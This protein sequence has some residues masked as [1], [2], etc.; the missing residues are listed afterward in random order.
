MTAPNPASLNVQLTELNNRSRAYSARLWYVPLAYMGAAGVVLAQVK[1]AALPVVLLVTGVVGLLLGWH[2]VGIENGRSRATEALKHLEVQLQLPASAQSRPAY[3]LPML[4]ITFGA[5]VASLVASYLLWP[6]PA[7]IPATAPPPTQ[8]SMPWGSIGEVL[9]TIGEFG[10]L[11][12]AVAQVALQVS[13]RRDRLRS[14]FAA[15]YAEYWRLQALEIEWKKADLVAYATDE[16]L[17]PDVLVPRDWGTLIRLLGEI[18][19]AT[20]A[21]G[22]FA[23]ASLNN[24]VTDARRIL[25]LVR[26]GATGTGLRNLETE[27][28]DSLEQA[29]MCLNDAMRAAPSWLQRHEITVADPESRMGKALERRLLEG[30]GRLIDPAARH[31]PRLGVV[32]KYVGRWLAAAGYWLNPGVERVKKPK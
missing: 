31:E 13:E 26:G 19:S 2:L 16:V 23:Y 10:L 29:V 15:L 28:K 7:N 3:T 5:A 17:Y 24:A 4:A 21:L 14:A 9:R 27:C 32:G 18:S 30:A 12:F 8:A 1:A 22:G 6:R 20:A 25:N 11:V